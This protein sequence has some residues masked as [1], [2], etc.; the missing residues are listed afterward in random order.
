MDFKGAANTLAIVNALGDFENGAYAAKLC[1]DLVAFGF[2][3]WYLPAA[4][5][6]NIMYQQLGPTGN[7][8][9]GSGDIPSGV[10]WSSSEFHVFGAWRQNFGTGLQFDV[11]K[12]DNVR[13]RCV[14]R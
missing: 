10:Y 8:F 11:N 9:D 14:R 7:G 12:D 1:A 13:C 3:D 6:L 2:D 5:E 4:G